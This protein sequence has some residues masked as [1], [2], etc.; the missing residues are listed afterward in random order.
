MGN[1]RASSRA[2]DGCRTPSRGAYSPI[3]YGHRPTGTSTKYGTA[4][5]RCRPVSTDS[6]TPRASPASPSARCATAAGWHRRPVASRCPAN[7]A[8]RPGTRSCRSTLA[9]TRNSTAV[10]AHRLLEAGGLRGRRVVL[11]FGE[12][13]WASHASP[14]VRAMWGTTTRRTPPA[15]PGRR[16]DSTSQRTSVP[17]SAWHTGHDRPMPRSGPCADQ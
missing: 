8:S 15:R 16:I 1:A 17:A 14:Q 3:R 2:V 11:T 5:R 9:S 4:A 13:T 6:S 12:A 10:E 7:A